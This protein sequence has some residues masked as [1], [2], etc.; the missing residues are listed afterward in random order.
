[1]P[2]IGPFDD[3]LALMRTDD[4]GSLEVHRFT[5]GALDR[6]LPS[7]GAYAAIAFPGPYTVLPGPGAGDRVLRADGSRVLRSIAVLSGRALNGG[8]GALSRPDRVRY[9]GAWY[10]VS[11]SNTWVD[12]AGYHSTVCVLAD[13][14]EDQPA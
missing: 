5:G 14:P 7:G 8:D 6:G 10:V 3:V 4:V 12:V 1:M 11:K 9:D 2:Q 13:E